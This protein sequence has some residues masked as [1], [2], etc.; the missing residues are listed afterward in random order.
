MK[1]LIRLHCWETNSSSSHSISL[2]KGEME[3]VIDNLYP[4]QDG[5]IH[6]DVEE[7]GWSW[8]KFNDAKTKLSY[9]YQDHVN[10]ETLREVVMEQTGATEVTFGNKDDGYIDHDSCGTA[11]SVCMDKESTRNFIFNK[12]SWLFTGN[13]NSTP[14]PTFYHTPEI[15]DGRM[16]VPKYTHELVIEGMEKTTK[17]LNYP[18]VEELDKGISSLTN[19]IL[20]TEDGSF[21]DNHDIFWQ[22]NRP[23]GV[24]YEKNW[25][26][27]QDFSKNEILF[28]KENDWRWDEV[29]K[30]VPRE[31]ITYDKRYKLITEKARKIEGLVKAVKFSINEI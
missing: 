3:F 24:F 12:N 19:G 23:R 16:I 20:V 29:E 15:R 6:V 2:A 18:T 27:H 10:E 1:K 28:L 21:I 9:A 26:L 22:I 17:Y 5:I 8:L 7:F 11:K 4:N 31:G 30:S 25:S 14:D 13:D